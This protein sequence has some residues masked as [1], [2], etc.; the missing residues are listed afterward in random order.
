MR[1]VVFV[2]VIV[3]RAIRDG[4]I[5]N[6]DLRRVMLNDHVREA[7]YMQPHN[8]KQQDQGHDNHID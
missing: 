1:K 6:Q 4:P 8:G 3:T 2:S 7:A 5:P